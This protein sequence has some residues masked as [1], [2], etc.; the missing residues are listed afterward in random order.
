MNVG[1][2]LLRVIGAYKRTL[3]ILALF[4]HNPACSLRSTENRLKFTSTVFAL[5]ECVRHRFPH[6][7]PEEASMRN[8]SPALRCKA[9]R[10]WE[11][12]AGRQARKT[13]TAP[14]PLKPLFCLNSQ[15][16]TRCRQ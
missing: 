6:D 15:C 9:G 1:L 2:G 16:P 12:D 13:P 3:F 4:L 14:P 11:A 8:L 5:T 7:E 10:R